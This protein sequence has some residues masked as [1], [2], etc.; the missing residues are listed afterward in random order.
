[1]QRGGYTVS[2]AVDVDWHNIAIK[3]IEES[4]I[5]LSFAFA[6]ALGWRPLRKMG[7]TESIY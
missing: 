3:L 2:L 5:G 4:D 7:L 6:Y 1:M